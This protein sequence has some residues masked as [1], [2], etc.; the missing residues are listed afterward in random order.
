MKYALE[1]FIDEAIQLELNAAAIYTIFSEAIPEDAN[2]WATLAWEEKNHAA[3]LKTGKDVLMPID[4]FPV[5]ILPN[6][7]QA[8][9]DTNNWLNSLI[10]EF[11]ACKPDRKTAFSTAVKI[12]SSAGEQHFQRV[13]ES[14]AKS[15]FMKILQ[16]LCEDDIHHLNKIREYMKSCG[17]TEEISGNNRKNILIVLDDDSVA[18]LLKTLLESEGDIDIVRNGREGLQK[19]QD[20][21]Y[22]LVVSGVEMEVVDGIQFYNEAKGLYSDLQ[23][24]FLFFTSEPSSERISFFQD[25]DVRYL[26]KPSTINEIRSAALSI[27]GQQQ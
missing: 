6:V 20:N 11:N 16:E 22:G 1:Q 5:E 4:Q 19:V 23:K 13:M 14:S 2:F 25:E 9:L 18:R 26:T 27:L 3:V 21:D 12:E 15:N 7:I 10:E 24:R 17:E 8:L